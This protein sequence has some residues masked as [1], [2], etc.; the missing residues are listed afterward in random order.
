LSLILKLKQWNLHDLLHRPLAQDLATFISHMDH[1]LNS[2]TMATRSA[3]VRFNS[4]G[5]PFFR[6]Y[7]VIE[8]NPSPDEGIGSVHIEKN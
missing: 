2:H 3:M 4:K 1:F 6:R 8:R 5:H 7:G